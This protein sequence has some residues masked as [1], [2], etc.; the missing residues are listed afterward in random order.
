MVPSRFCVAKTKKKKR[1]I[2]KAET[3]KRLSPRL[4]YYCFNHSECLEFKNFSSRLTMVA[5]NTCQCSM[6][7]PLWNPFR[8]PCIFLPTYHRN[9]S[10]NPL[11]YGLR[12]IFYWKHQ[13]PSF[14]KSYFIFFVEVF[15]RE[16]WTI[17]M[18]HLQILS[19]RK[20]SYLRNL[21]FWISAKC[22]V[23]KLKNW[24]LKTNFC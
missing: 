7:P 24:F 18:C 22:H 5:D 16:P 6:A 8:R 15:Y 23:L 11:E 10:C 17:R 20:I 2:F 13:W 12:L 3:I 14:H 4:K 19:H 1:K 21:W 9:I